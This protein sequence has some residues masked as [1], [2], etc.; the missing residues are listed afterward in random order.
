MSFLKNNSNFFTSV[1]VHV[2]VTEPLKSAYV[3]SAHAEVASTKDH[4]HYLI[5][6]SYPGIVRTAETTDRA[7]MCCSRDIFL[8]SLDHGWT[9]STVENIMEPFGDSHTLP[10]RPV[11]RRYTPS[12]NH[13][14][15]GRGGV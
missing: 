4:R 14:G 10:L 12:M 7:T 11:V 13:I 9:V 3:V 6:T 8:N 2:Y 1:K 15:E 5:T